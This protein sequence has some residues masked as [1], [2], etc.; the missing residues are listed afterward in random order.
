MNKL[1]AIQITTTD[2]RTAFA[3]AVLVL[4]FVAFTLLQDFLRAALQHSS[5]YFSESFMF[6]AFWWLFAPLLYAQYF[7][8]RYKNNGRLAFRLAVIVI[9]ILL[10]L[11]A[12]PLLV[13]ALSTAFY[14]HTYVF[15]QTLRYTLSEHVYTLLLLYSIPVLAF[16]LLSKKEKT[17]AMA[18][19]QQEIIA[20]PFISSILV[21]DGYKKHPVA[22]ADILYFSAS[23][24]YITLHLEGKKYLHTAT[25]KSISAKLDP[26]QFVRVHKSTIININRVAFYTTR[27]NGDYDLT[28]KNSIQIRVSR[29]FAP[30]FKDLFNKTHQVTTI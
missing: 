15:Q 11:L 29:N 20:L 3:L 16:R 26:G 5:F 21:A 9:P 13:W 6:S 24:P 30:G 2:R 25:L 28:M 1:K 8:A 18:R 19:S 23:P 10:H 17:A 4:V 12:F 27:L 14:Y 7:T 22:V